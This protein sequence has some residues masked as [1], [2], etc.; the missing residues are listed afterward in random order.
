MPRLKHSLILIGSIAALAL[1]FYKLVQTPVIALT[2]VTVIN[3]TGAERLPN[4]TS[5]PRRPHHAGEAPL[6]QRLGSVVPTP[7]ICGS[8]L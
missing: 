6:S 5:F 8:N 2:N 1:G 3:G 4:Q 7:E